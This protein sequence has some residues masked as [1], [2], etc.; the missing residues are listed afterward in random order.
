MDD[1]DNVQ[2][3]SVPA[4]DVDGMLAGLAKWLRILGFDAAHPCNMPSEGR[5]FVTR[6]TSI[7]HPEAIIITEDSPLEQLIQILEQ[8]RIVPDPELLMS[9]C[10]VCNH[11][12]EEISK[13]KVEGRVP[14][15]VFETK[16]S[17]HQCVLCGRLYW[18]GG[19]VERIKQRLEKVYARPGITEKSQ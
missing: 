16:Q 10:M 11:P 12:V 7:N 4:F 19:H 5:V 2:T 13:D 3:S 8:K 14:R 9:R 15:R 1:H 18:V 6:K 17:F